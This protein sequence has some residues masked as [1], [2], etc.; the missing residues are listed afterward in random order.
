[1]A[2]PVLRWRLRVGH[3]YRDL[4]VWQKAKALAVDVYRVTAT[5]PKHETY[6]LS[7][8]LQRAAV[9][10]VSNIAEGQGR[11]NKREFVQFLG[12]ARGSVVEAAT[13]L[14][15]AHDLGYI[16]DATFERLD[17]ETRNVHGLINRLLDSLQT[18]ASSI[19]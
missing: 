13:Q 11:L 6:S 12:I 16:D 9:S 17:L 14:E 8:Q 15:I 7:Q 10:V 3:S 2:E 19:P 18:R 4:L 1:M 5:F